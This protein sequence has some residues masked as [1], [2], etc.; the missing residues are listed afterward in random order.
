VKSESKRFGAD[1]ALTVDL[2]TGVLTSCQR[3]IGWSLVDLLVV[4]SNRYDVRYPPYQEYPSPRDTSGAP[5]I[6]IRPAF[7]ADWTLPRPNSP[8]I[9]PEDF[10]ETGWPPHAED[11]NAGYWHFTGS[12][13]AAWVAEQGLNVYECM[14]VGESLAGA[15]FVNTALTNNN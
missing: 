3:V 6:T 9:Q 14:Q 15:T 10:V 8:K 5:P 1:I 7:A 11:P 2:A 13:E 4:S 12:S